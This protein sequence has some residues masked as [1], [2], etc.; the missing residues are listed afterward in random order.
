MSSFYSI[1]TIVN[2]SSQGLSSVE[3]TRDLV[4]LSLHNNGIFQN[5]TTIGR[6]VEVEVEVYTTRAVVGPSMM[7]VVQ[8]YYIHYKR[9][10]LEPV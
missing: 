1:A 5:N 2:Q 8:I 9:K 6:E 10:K 3:T 4:L 7:T